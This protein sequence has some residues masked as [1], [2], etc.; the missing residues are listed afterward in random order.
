MPPGAEAGRQLIEPGKPPSL[1]MEIRKPPIL[2]PQEDAVAQTPPGDDDVRF[3]LGGVTLEG[4]TLLEAKETDA[5]VQPLLGKEVS[6]SRLFELARELTALYRGKGYLLAQVSLP[7]QRI[8]L[9]GAVHLQAIEGS[10]ESIDIEGG[11]PRGEPLIRA[12]LD[13]LLND[14]SVTIARIERALL[15][16]EDLE[17][18]AV[19]TRLGAGSVSGKLKMVIKVQRDDV[20]GQLYYDNMSSPYQGRDQAMLT[21]QINNL[22][23]HSDYTRVSLQKPFDS[24]KMT[25]WAFMQGIMLG[26]SGARLE[27]SYSDSETHPGDD[28]QVYQLQGNAK[29]SKAQVL[30]PLQ[31]S[32]YYNLRA[33]FGVQH[34]DSRQTE[35]NGEVDLYHD[36]LNMLTAGGSVDWQD[37][38]QGGGLSI[39][40]LNFTQGVSADP[41]L[42]SRKNAK[43][44]F[45]KLDFFF[46]RFQVISEKVSLQLSAGGQYAWAPLVSSAQYGLGSYPFGRGF[47]P[48]TIVGSQAL[49]GKLELRYDLLEAIGKHIS[50]SISQLSVFG[51]YDGGKEWDY[52]GTS[53]S[54]SSNGIGL[55]GVLDAYS[56]RNIDKRS[57]DFEVFVAWKQHAPSYIANTSPVLRARVIMNF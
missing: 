39:L 12:Y 27:L 48:S 19:N 17:G 7:P 13:P 44:E 32:R 30:L 1:P 26:N 9:E 33:Q 49:A 4:V 15:L 14:K 36:R 45:A 55:R 21:G 37:N 20:S 34:L 2:M 57:L 47:E 43:G 41:S 46:N 38:W 6:L 5:L 23:G 8:G 42:P 16:A 50:P 18:V 51:F 10:I 54:L 35:F 31:R 11:D 29:L 3:L 52:Y 53:A 24:S 22:F 25:N 28:L 40:M 56:T